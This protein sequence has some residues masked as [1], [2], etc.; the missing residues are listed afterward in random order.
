MVRGGRAQVMRLQVD[1]GD[2]RIATYTSDGVVVASPTGSTA[3]LAALRNT[4]IGF[5]FQFHYLLPEFTAEENVAMPRL[6]RR[7]PR[8][9]ALEEARKDPTVRA[10]LEVFDGSKIRSVETRPQGELKP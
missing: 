3:Q 4:T 6:I 8:P 1:V 7:V 2:S 10:I 5:V 9:E